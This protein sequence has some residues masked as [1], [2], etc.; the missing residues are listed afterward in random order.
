MSLINQMLT[1]LDQRQAA[2]SAMDDSADN[3]NPYISTPFNAASTK[4]KTPIVK[5]GF[6]ALLLLLLFITSYYSYLIY[7]QQTTAASGNSIVASKPK[8]V[9]KKS[10]KIIP[11]QSRHVQVK[12]NKPSPQPVTTLVK[13]QTI[14][15]PVQQAMATTPLVEN[16][17]TAEPISSN[18][19]DP[20]LAEENFNTDMQSVKKYQLQL[21]PKQEAEVAYTKGYSL[22]KQNKVYSAESKLLLALEH[23]IN[24]IKAREM[25]VGLYLK[26]GR[27]VEAKDILIKGIVLLPSYTNFTKLYARL[28]L[29]NNETDKAVKTLL[30]HKPAIESDPN[31]YALLAASYQRQKNHNAA[32]NTYVN[33]LKIKPREGIWWVGMAISLE[34]LNKIQD[35]LNAYEKARQTGT[36]NT[37]VSNYSSQRLKQLKLISNT[38]EQ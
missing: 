36:L 31:Y 35:A 32:A 21:S 33:L 27:K 29:D 24:H 34:A 26:T 3:T 9:Q 4:H 25:L 11:V 22:L 30:Q 15:K 14:S 37:R 12:I 7:A 18:Q 28:L 20:L 2:A 17:D 38:D 8:A 19:I 23:N 6:S 16:T 5:I 10:P 13:P 1:D